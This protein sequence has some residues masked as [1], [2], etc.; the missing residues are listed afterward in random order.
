MSEFCDC[1]L[2]LPPWLRSNR[3]M[4]SLLDIV[5]E[6]ESSQWK[7]V[8]SQKLTFNNSLFHNCSLHP[9][10]RPYHP[11]S[12]IWDRHILWLQFNSTE[13]VLI[14]FNLII[15]YFISFYYQIRFP[16]RWGLTEH[17]VLTKKV[18]TMPIHHR[19]GK[20]E[21]INLHYW[22][23]CRQTFLKSHLNISV[24]FFLLFYCFENL[25]CFWK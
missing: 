15:F 10:S 20:I 11:I 23:L 7:E 2:F 16:E 13:F 17:V 9:T 12:I 24:C 18:T 8:V 19:A 3:N 4:L 25:I 1:A 6:G 21:D 5:I 22:W 14:Q